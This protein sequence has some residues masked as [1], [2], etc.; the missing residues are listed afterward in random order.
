MNR[1]IRGHSLSFSL[2]SFSVVLVVFC[3]PFRS[4]RPAIFSIQVSFRYPSTSPI[5]G[6]VSLLLAA[7]IKRTLGAHAKLAKKPI[8]EMNMTV[9]KFTEQSAGCWMQLVCLF[10]YTPSSVLIYMHVHH[11]AR[12]HAKN[13]PSAF[14]RAA[15]LLGEKL[16]FAF[17]CVRFYLTK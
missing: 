8:S 6:I 17:A 13:R 16:V 5:D 2:L 12:T 14:A 11:R 3:R 7:A 9:A 1:S 10:V 4:D 15:F